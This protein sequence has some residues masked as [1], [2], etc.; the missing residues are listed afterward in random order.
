MTTS[1]LVLRQNSGWLVLEAWPFSIEM[2]RRT[3]ELCVVN[4]G[5]IQ[6]TQK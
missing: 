6:M 1:Y 2:K 4:I 5:K 3:K